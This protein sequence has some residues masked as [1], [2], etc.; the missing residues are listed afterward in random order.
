MELYIVITFQLYKVLN[1]LPFFT[2]V[3]HSIY[4]HEVADLPLPC[5]FID[6]SLG[7][8]EHKLKKISIWVTGKLYN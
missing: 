3:Q 7:K 2:Q 1:C 4:H 5:M 6:E 8:Y